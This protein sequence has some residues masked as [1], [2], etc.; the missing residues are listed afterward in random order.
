[1]PAWQKADMSLARPTHFAAFMMLVP[2]ILY[3]GNVLLVNHQDLTYFRK[4]FLGN[5]VY[6]A[7]PHL[8]ML[9]AFFNSEMRTKELCE[10]LAILNGVLLAFHCWLMLAVPRHESSMAWIFYFPIWC[11]T[12]LAFAYYYG[13]N[14]KA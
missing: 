2:A 6:M 8:V 12:L 13:G 10:T 5:Y 11:A 9:F 7:A 4:Y 3:L 14:E 1:M